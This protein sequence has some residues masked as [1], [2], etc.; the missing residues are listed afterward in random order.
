MDALYRICM[1]GI[2]LLFFV[3]I[4][5]ICRLVAFCLLRRGGYPTL[6]TER[7]GEGEGEGEGEREN[8]VTVRVKGI[9]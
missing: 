4:V 6:V 5:G 9:Q 2:L 1:G 3:A 8:S 7:E